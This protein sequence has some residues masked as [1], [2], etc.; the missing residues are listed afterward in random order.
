MNYFQIINLHTLFEIQLY[1]HLSESEHRE[2]NWSQDSKKSFMSYRNHGR[3]PVCPIIHTYGCWRQ[4]PWAP[5]LVHQAQVMGVIFCRNACWEPCWGG[6]HRAILQLD[7]GN[8]CPL[9]CFLQNSLSIFPLISLPP[10]FEVPL[11]FYQEN[12]FSWSIFIPFCIMNYLAFKYSIM[13][14]FAFWESLIMNSNKY[15]YFILSQWCYDFLISVCFVALMGY[16]IV[17]LHN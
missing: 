6:S 1:A 7:S 17:D 5:S 9:E 13:L 3:F 15:R 14:P 8:K 10:D 11:E 4:K 16:E 12:M 2:E